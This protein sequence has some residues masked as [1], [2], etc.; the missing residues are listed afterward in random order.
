MSDIRTII[1]LFSI[2]NGGRRFPIISGFRSPIGFVKGQY[3]DV[4]YEL[5][6]R[7]EL[8]PGETCDAF[9]IFMAPLLIRAE[10]SIGSK[11]KIWERGIIGEGEITEIVD[12]DSRI[13]STITDAEIKEVLPRTKFDI[14][15]FKLL[16]IIGF[17]KL[18]VIIADLLEWTK[19]MNWPVAK[20]LFALLCT[21]E[22]EIVKP[23]I[24]IIN[25]GDDEWIWSILQGL[26]PNLPKSFQK[27]LIPELANYAT[28]DIDRE[29]KEDE[30]KYL[31]IVGNN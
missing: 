12:I 5:I 11:F 6:N 15:N 16:Y 7:K 29:Y 4:Q 10:L 26:I 13:K 19:D 20:M 23:I 30:I 25:S 27:E 1:S 2:A 28:K 22:H 14:E 21:A 9:L 18:N 17:P 24:D 8:H 31:R 3:S